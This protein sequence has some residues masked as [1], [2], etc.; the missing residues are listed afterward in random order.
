MTQCPQR[1]PAMCGTIKRI[2]L[3]N[4][5]SHALFTID[6]GEID[7]IS[8]LNGSMYDACPTPKP[9]T[10]SLAPSLMPEHTALPP[11][12]EPTR[13]AP[14]PALP[15]MRHGVVLWPADLGA[16][17]PLRVV[18]HARRRQERDLNGHNGRAGWQ[19]ARHRAGD[20]LPRPHPHRRIVWHPRAFHFSR[21]P[22]P[23]YISAPSIFVPSFLLNNT[24]FGWQPARALVFCGAFAKHVWFVDR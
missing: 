12:P 2:H 5:M 15:I 4:F 20:G 18:S 14:G 21:T 7:F 6:L 17:L 3:Q 19:A 10:P 13:M 24:T 22:P 1:G 9:A 11:S 16:F 8:G 23:I